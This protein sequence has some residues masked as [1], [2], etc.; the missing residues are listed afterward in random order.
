MILHRLSGISV[1]GRWLGAD[2]HPKAYSSTIRLQFE[3]GL[4]LASGVYRRQI[5]L[6]SCLNGSH[7]RW[8]AEFARMPVSSTTS[9]PNS[10]PPSAAP[11]AANA[12][13]GTLDGMVCQECV[14]GTD[15]S[16]ACQ[17]VNGFENPSRRLLAAQPYFHFLEALPA[18]GLGRRFRDHIGL[19]GSVNIGLQNHPTIEKCVFLIS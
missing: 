5:A 11:P 4:L 2:D 15:A 13:T 16:I 19:A 6:S 14:S 8:K 7:V 17:A 3:A 1:R 18:P 12:R 9:F 10:P